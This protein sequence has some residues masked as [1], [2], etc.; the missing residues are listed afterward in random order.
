MTVG[1]DG[2]RSQTNKISLDNSA[3]LTAVKLDGPKQRACPITLWK[4]I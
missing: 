2:E 4:C 3:C 1:D